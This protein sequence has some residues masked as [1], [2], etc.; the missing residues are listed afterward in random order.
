M[1]KCPY[2]LH[3]NPANAKFCSNCGQAVSAT[4]KQCGSCHARA[5]LEAKFCH[6][7][8]ARFP[9]Q[10]IQVALGEEKVRLIGAIEE[11][12][13]PFQKK[14]DQM[15]R[16]GN[17]GEAMEMYESGLKTLEIR[18]GDS[19]DSPYLRSH[20]GLMLGLS[21][22]H[23]K[24]GEHREALRLLGEARERLAQLDDLPSR[25]LLA[26]IHQHIGVNCYRESAQS[27]AAMNYYEGL[28]ILGG[29][30][31]NEQGARLYQ[32]LGNLFRALG[33]N[34]TAK[35]YHERCRQI[36]LKIGDERGT[37]VAA[38]NLGVL[39][40][41]MGDYPTAENYYQEALR[42]KKRIKDQEGM[43]ICHANIGYLRYEQEALVEA[44][45]YLNA[46][47]EQAKNN[48][49]WIVPLC[50]NFLARIAF[51]EGDAGQVKNCVEK[52]ER[53]LTGETVSTLNRLKLRELQALAAFSEK[54]Y[55]A[56]FTAFAAGQ[57]ILQET[58]GGFDGAVFQM[59][60]GRCLHRYGEQEKPAG[61]SEELKK[62][63]VDLI[64]LAL[65]DF[66]KLENEKYIKKCYG[67][68]EDLD[69]MAAR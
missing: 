36:R 8:G 45:E 35:A 10:P 26:D 20:C 53:A 28:K 31:E 30:T 13:D 44:K 19:D 40:T 63:A 62:R 69:R 17:L 50:Y 11:L 49:P 58:A 37:S 68:L 60:Y 7:C 67:Y 65:D 39:Y 21:I 18:F 1:S 5:P 2:C 66:K 61:R 6:E 24:K 34:T 55:E 33:N 48:A 64:G 16:T 42:L 51:L 27:D 54:Q 52:M 22:A 4:D 46:A 59:N 23:Q 29:L 3:D 15:L 9:V 43:V 47:L 57:E 32:G 12:V 38:V 41:Q 56:A 25:L 14:G